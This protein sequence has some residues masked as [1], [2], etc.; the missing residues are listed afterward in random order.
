MMGEN[1]STAIVSIPLE[2]L[3]SLKA[4]LNQK[5]R[6]ILELEQMKDVR[7]T[8]DGDIYEWGE[9]N[10]KFDSRVRIYGNYDILKKDAPII[11]EEIQNSMSD[12]FNG[13]IINSKIA[14][15]YR[16]F[17]KWF[18]KIFNCE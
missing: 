8:I 16:K 3:E 11:W 9:M 7:L 10:R 14:R 13:I 2:E 15:F 12:M 18:H 4:Q 17:P 5:D 1:K 6:R